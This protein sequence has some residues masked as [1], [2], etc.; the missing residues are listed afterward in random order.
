MDGNLGGEGIAGS[1]DGVDT[2][3]DGALCPGKDGNG[4]LIISTVVLT[5]GNI[6]VFKDVEDP[7]EA[8]DDAVAITVGERVSKWTLVHRVL[9]GSVPCTEAG[10]GPGISLLEAVLAA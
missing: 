9:G 8:E 7:K 4:V 2:G 10:S 5:E 6:L 1:T 3:G